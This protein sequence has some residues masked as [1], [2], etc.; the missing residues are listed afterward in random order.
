MLF[1]RRLM[2]HSMNR[3]Q[4]KLHRIGTFDVFKLSMSYF[5]DK[6]YI[7]DDGVSNLAYFH[8]NVFG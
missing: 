3:I 6:R 5:D 4:S 1:G 2:K 7:I 8:R